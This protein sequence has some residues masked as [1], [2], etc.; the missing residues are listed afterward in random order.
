MNAVS[1]PSEIDVS[2]RLPLLVLIISGAIWLVISSVFSLLASL[3]FHKPDLFSNSFTFSYGH[4]VAAR[5]TSFLY[6]AGI[7]LGLAV[8]LW[9]FCRVGR[10][11]LAQRI[12]VTV[13]A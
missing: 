8:T 6:G 3:V 7:Q 11:L 4:L 13:G 5:T 9:L 2:C 12:L 10:T 1:K